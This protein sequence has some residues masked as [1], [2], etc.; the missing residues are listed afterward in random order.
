MAA[1]WRG[2]CDTTLTYST[3][4]I[5]RANRAFPLFGMLNQVLEL[6]IEAVLDAPLTEIVIL[7]TRARRPSS[8]V[9]AMMAPVA[10][11]SFLG[12]PGRVC[13]ND[14]LLRD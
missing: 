12:T 5:P 13:G 4:T 14:D 11:G 8:L 10:L 9:L 7:A 1:L 6:Q 2:L 3:R